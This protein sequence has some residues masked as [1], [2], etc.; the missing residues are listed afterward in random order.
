M[1]GF[2]G[3]KAL[4]AFLQRIFEFIDQIVF[5]GAEKTSVVFMTL[6]KGR[7]IGQGDKAKQG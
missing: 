2:Y 7:I 3:Q 5:I 1:W 4:I 6:P